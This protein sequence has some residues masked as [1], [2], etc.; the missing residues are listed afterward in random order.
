[1]AYIMGDRHQMTFLPPSIEEYV[2]EDDPVRA[3]DTFVESLDFNQ[4]GITIDECKA[5]AQAYYPKSLLKLLLYGYAYG[6]RS[7]RKLERAAKH[8]LAFIWLTGDLQPDYRTIARFRKNNHTAL[9]KVLTQCVHMC[10]KLDLIDGNRLFV[11]GTKIKANASLVRTWT[12]ERCER[13]LTEITKNIDS[14]LAECERVDQEEETT[15]SLVQMKDNLRNKETMAAAIKDILTEL[16]ESKKTYTNTTDDDSVKAK[17]DRGT[18]M[19]HNA[20]VTVDGKHG[21]IVSNA[22]VHQSNDSNQ[23][24]NQVEQAQAVLGKAPEVACAD[25]GY[26]SV[27][28]L[29][30]IPAET[31][32]IVPSQQQAQGKNS[33]QFRNPFHKAAFC[34][35]AE[36]DE[37]RCP[38]GN[39]LHAIPHT[40]FNRDETVS[41]QA[42]GE[43]CTHCAFFGRCTRS[44]SGRTIVRLKDEVVKEQLEARYSSA[45]GQAT[46]KQR[47]EKAELPFAYIKHTL[48]I[49]QFLLRRKRG[50]DTELALVAT[51]YNVTRMISLIGGIG[52][53]MARLAVPPVP[54]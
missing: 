27:A 37:Y 38:A 36:A 5:G 24:S 1:M 50:V 14:L 13:Y 52:A 51:C 41:Y 42:K 46:Y 18:K 19:Y 7:S 44:S 25:S 16:E 20:Q 23:L 6:I 15:G 17:S 47:K 40:I 28:D 26:F 8:N 49:R 53:F 43:D 3:Y 54:G 9:K 45:E 48:G 21:L 29:K 12:K 34:Y 2:S 10:I 11:D 32:V 22:S 31:T 4:L 30:K 33:P 39:R 35:D